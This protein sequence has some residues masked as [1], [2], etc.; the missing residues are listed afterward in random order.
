MEELV[1]KKLR[2]KQMLINYILSLFVL[3]ITSIVCLQ[4]KSLKTFCI[5]AGAVCLCY[6]IIELMNRSHGEIIIGKLIPS[7]KPLY[8]Y[9]RE[10]LGIEYNKLKNRQ[11]TFIMF[12]AVIIIY[13]GIVTPNSHPI[14]YGRSAFYYFFPS[15]LMSLIVSNISFY[16]H[17]KKI[18]RSNTEELKGYA[19]ET[20]IE[21]TVIGI[22]FA[23]ILIGL[24]LAFLLFYILKVSSPNF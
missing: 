6:I 14:G 23:I 24:F 21:G 4:I 16:R 20:L 22:L 9:E 7:L 8:A 12:F 2:R 1:L 15:A 17:I 13:L 19:N 10:K 18:D 11:L 5:L 3:A